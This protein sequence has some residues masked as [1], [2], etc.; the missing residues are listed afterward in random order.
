MKKSV[1]AAF[2]VLIT[3]ISYSAEKPIVKKFNQ[4][5]DKDMVL[6]LKIKNNIDFLKKK[7]IN[8]APL[9][10]DYSLLEEAV[11]EFTHSVD[12]A[13]KSLYLLNSKINS[14]YKQSQNYA[15]GNKKI[16]IMYYLMIITGIV[17]II[18]MVISSIF[19]NPGRK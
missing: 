11:N 12:S 5:A 9:E 14:L 16:E 15:G 10:K 7:N 3:I 19:I 8:I 1:L 13:D 4:L 6:F 17:V 2:I 18:I